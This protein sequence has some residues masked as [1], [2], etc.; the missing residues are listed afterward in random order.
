MI[1][2]VHNTENKSLNPPN[3]E[4]TL[5]SKEAKCQTVH[6]KKDSFLFDYVVKSSV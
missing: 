3:P 4:R 1:Y 6:K 2:L 5:V